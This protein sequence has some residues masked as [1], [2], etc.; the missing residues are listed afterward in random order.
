MIQIN[1][2]EEVGEHPNAIKILSAFSI[3]IQ[4]DMQSLSKLIPWHT[5]HRA[6]PLYISML[7][8]SQTFFRAL[9]SMRNYCRTYDLIIG[10]GD[11]NLDNDIPHQV[12]VFFLLLSQ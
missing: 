9:L 11:Y 2:G 10:K 5:S 4:T 12:I 3:S 1:D 8:L 7:F 6:L